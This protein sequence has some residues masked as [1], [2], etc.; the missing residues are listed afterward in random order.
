MIE[1]VV[2]KFNIS[3]TISTSENKLHIQWAEFFE[4][5]LVRF[6]QDGIAFL[7]CQENVRGKNK[8]LNR[9]S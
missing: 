8:T 1:V 7:I 5:K 2:I 9:L 4:K 3:I 6:A